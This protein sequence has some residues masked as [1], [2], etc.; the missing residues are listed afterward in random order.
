MYGIVYDSVYYDCI[1]CMISC[2]ILCIVYLLL[3]K[4]NWLP[5]EAFSFLVNCTVDSTKGLWREKSGDKIMYCEVNCDSCLIRDKSRYLGSFFV[6][7]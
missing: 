1:L 4:E 2:I 3:A 6:S 7:V 5:V